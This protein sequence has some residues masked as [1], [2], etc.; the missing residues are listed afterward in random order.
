MAKRDVVTDRPRAGIL[1][2]AVGGLWLVTALTQP[3]V[4]A[5]VVDLPKDAMD[6]IVLRQTVHVA[7]HAQ[8]R[9]LHHVRTS[10][11]RAA[12]DGEEQ[13]FL[14]RMSLA[15]IPLTRDTEIGMP[16]RI[17]V[18]ALGMSFVDLRPYARER[19]RLREEVERRVCQNLVEQ[20]TSVCSPRRREVHN[21]ILYYLKAAHGLC[22][23]DP[24]WTPSDL[25][26][27]IT[28][29][30]AVYKDDEYHA[31][32]THYLEQPQ[33]RPYVIGKNIYTAI[34]FD[35]VRS[36]FDHN[37]IGMVLSEFLGVRRDLHRRYP[38]SEHVKDLL[39]RWRWEHLADC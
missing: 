8:R 18:E 31:R 38:L 32:L 30:H 10:N 34:Y 20:Q 5:C 29:L 16:M 28:E 6:Y 23:A 12:P 4:A 15:Y 36:S 24:S 35:H 17:A 2:T 22:G 27:E 9:L 37:C 33:N 14:R 11:P 3:A 1:L 26:A 25:V 7:A 19:D 39:S 21:F 13:D